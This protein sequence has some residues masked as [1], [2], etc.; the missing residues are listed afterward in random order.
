MEKK[1]RKR[2]KN[3]SVIVQKY[4]G[5]QAAIFVEDRGKS[6]RKPST[7]TARN[8]FISNVSLRIS[9]G[10]LGYISR[11]GYRLPTLAAGGEKRSE[12]GKTG[13]I[14]STVLCRTSGRE[15]GAR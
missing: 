14:L 5:L 13:S 3:D 4:G 9:S 8:L 6:S 1:K 2:R 10:V 12:R 15:K 11:I 7:P